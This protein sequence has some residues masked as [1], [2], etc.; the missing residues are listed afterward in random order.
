M[1]KRDFIFPPDMPE[2]MRRQYENAAD[3]KEMEQQEWAHSLSRFFDSLDLEQTIVLRKMMHGVVMTTEHSDIPSFWEGLLT[4][5]MHFKYNSCLGC[6]ENHDHVLDAVAGQTE[7]AGMED[8]ELVG[9]DY[10]DMLTLYYLTVGERGQLVCKGCGTSSP[11]LKDRM[12]RE[13]GKEG[14]ATCIQKEKWG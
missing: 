4:G 2:E 6:G 13:P 9:Q 14:C 3:R 7:E 5:I 10:A 12:L 1:G 11:S 8:E